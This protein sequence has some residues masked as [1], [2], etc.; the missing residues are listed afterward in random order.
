MVRIN[1]IRFAGWL[2]MILAALYLAGCAGYM[3]SER[4]RS[5][6]EEAEQLA[7]EENFDLAIEK[8]A[9]AVEL[10]PGSKTYRIKMVSAKT[11]A[12]ASHIRKARALKEEGKLSEAVEEYRIAESFDRSVEVAT[13]EANEILQLLGAEKLA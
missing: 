7:D 9:E 6:F 10:E 1:K 13:Q 5:A 12:A 3:Q 4:A 2:V 11:R 8:Y